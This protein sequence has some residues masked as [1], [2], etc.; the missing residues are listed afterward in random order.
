ME[1][2]QMVVVDIQAM[3]GSIT[4]NFAQYKE[5][6][7]REMQPYQGAVVVED[8]YR[9]AYKSR[10]D[11]KKVIDAL[12]TKRKAVKRD[13]LMP[14]DEFEAKYKHM[15]TSLTDT[16]KALDEQIKGF[17]QKKVE[18]KTQ[19]INEMIDERLSKEPDYIEKLVRSCPFAI[20]NKSWENKTTSMR[21]ITSFFEE[22]VS[23]IKEHYVLISEYGEFAPEMLEFYTKSGDITDTLRQGSKLKERKASYD[24]TLQK[25]RA[26]AAQ[27]SVFDDVPQR[28]ETI[29]LPK[30]K[31]VLSPK[32]T[33]VLDEPFPANEKETTVV[34]VAM[35]LSGPAYTIKWLMDAA[36]LVGISHER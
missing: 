10:A 27:P 9:D 24:L 33:I 13:Y 11:L 2:G 17:D 21:E 23:S 28:T 15:I 7:D 3:P 18:E 19:A 29:P 31:P 6:L 12:E 34:K 22:R 14:Y 36:D 30:E 26:V 32:S 1:Q 4:D 16:W 25:A 5:Q 35:T 20:W 8:N